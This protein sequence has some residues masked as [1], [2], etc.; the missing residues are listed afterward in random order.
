MS[1]LSCVSCSGPNDTPA[2]KSCSVCRFVTRT[3]HNIARGTCGRCGDCLACELQSMRSRTLDRRS[4][5]ASRRRR[6]A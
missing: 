3:K 4:V 6:A 5:E 1:G 2:Y